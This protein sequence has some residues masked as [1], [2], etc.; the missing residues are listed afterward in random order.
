MSLL[1]NSPNFGQIYWRGLI[2]NHNNNMYQIKDANTN[3]KYVYWTITNPTQLLESNKKLDESLTRVLLFVND[4]GMAITVPNEIVVLTWDGNNEQLVRD[5]IFGIYEDLGNHENK[6]IAIEQNIDGIS[7]TVGQNKSELL[8]EISKVDQKADSI[9]LSVKKVEKE[10]GDNKE[11]NELREN[12]NKS[13]IDFN[14]QLGLFKSD[15]NSF[16]TDNR[17]TTE[18]K[19]KINEHIRLLE[20]KRDA[21]ITF[22]DKI[23]DL[24]KKQGNVAQQSAI[25]SS[26]TK[27]I[28]SIANLKTY[29]TTAI[30]DGNITPSELTGIIDLFAKCNLAVVEMKNTI[31]EFLFLGAGGAIS[32]ELAKVN[33]K[34]DEIKLTVSSNSER[35][36]SAESQIIQQSNQ[37]AM[38]VDANGVNSII[39]QNPDSVQIGFNKINDRITIDSKRMHFK[40]AT[41]KPALTI[42]GGA[43]Y[44][45][46]W[47]N[48]NFL[49]GMQCINPATAS[50]SSFGFLGAKDCDSFQISRA[51]GWSSPDQSTPTG[52]QSVLAINFKDI[53]VNSGLVKGMHVFTPLY[54]TNNL[55]MAGN[56]IIGAN[57][58]GA[59]RMLC[60]NFYS[61]D[62]DEKLFMSYSRGNNAL[63]MGTDL[64]MNGFILSDATALRVGTSGDGFKVDSSGELHV[65]YNNIYNNFSSSYVSS[66]KVA[67]NGNCSVAKTI[68]ADDYASRITGGSIITGGSPTLENHWDILDSFDVERGRNGIEIVCE[69]AKSKYKT[70][71]N[72]CL[73]VNEGGETT[74]SNSSIIATLINAVKELKSENDKLKDLISALK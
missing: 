51:D 11:L 70:F 73:Q 9:D 30:S 2:V 64:H 58:I 38:K 55:A 14:S 21:I 45:Y 10:F 16:F 69:D 5:R 46:N 72:P 18:E 20:L 15:T 23:I 6:F 28:N 68:W 56:N 47:V 40:Y 33:I 62:S 17:V 63:Y 24:A 66:L 44:S 13:T 60:Q 61:S 37:I 27:F 26:K 36:G 74:L 8:E 67:T 59:T 54:L 4:K 25:N 12:F 19:N 52:L 31:D 71:L 29:I 39:Q 48:S 32:E 50:F 22:L 1:S 34:S 3:K 41:S 7:T 53:D 57:K 49:G 42:Q 43:M 65:N 35:L